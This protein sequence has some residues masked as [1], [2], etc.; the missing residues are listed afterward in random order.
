MDGE[1]RGRKGRGVG[2][3]GLVVQA[4][5]KVGIWAAVVAEVR[6]CI[7]WEEVVWRGQ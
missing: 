4:F 2:E 5:W 1:R 7:A 3:G 6:E